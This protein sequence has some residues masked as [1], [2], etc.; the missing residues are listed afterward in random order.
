MPAGPEGVKAMAVVVEVGK[1]ASDATNWNAI[2]AVVTGVAALVALLVGVLPLMLTSRRRKRQA[3]VLAQVLADNLS[4]QELHIRAAMQ[5]PRS[6]NGHVSAWEYQQISKATE[7]LDPKP[8]M[9]LISFSPNLPRYVV[10]AVAQC[11]AMLD[12]ARQRRVFLAEANPGETYSVAG[13]IGWYESVAS[14]LLTLRRALHRW[15]GNEP[16]EFAEDA[17]TLA[18]NLREVALTN[19][20]DWRFAQARA[21]ISEAP[22][23]Q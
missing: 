10:D 9:D 8:V 3:A 20:R 15:L 4:I 23:Q 14:D 17:K 2:S 7:F 16:Q 19:E 21:S 5:V 22:S 6:S 11:A 12:V 13:D 1:V 18:R